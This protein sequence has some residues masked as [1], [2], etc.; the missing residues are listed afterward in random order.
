MYDNQKNQGNNFGQIRE[1]NIKGK[2]QK[3]FV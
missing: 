1:N 2:D 3:F